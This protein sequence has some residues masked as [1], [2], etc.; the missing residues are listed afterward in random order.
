[1]VVQLLQLKA[2]GADV[3]SDTSN[4]TNAITELPLSFS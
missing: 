3:E 1:M 4:K 2:Y